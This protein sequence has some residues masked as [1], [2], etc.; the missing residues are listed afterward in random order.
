MYMKISYL[1]QKPV[2][3]WVTRQ[4]SLEEAETKMLREKNLQILYTIKI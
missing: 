3:V 2:S 4:I 1:Y